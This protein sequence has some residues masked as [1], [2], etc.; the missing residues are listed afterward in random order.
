V[1]IRNPVSLLLKNMAGIYIHIPFC[2][3]ACYYCDFHFS[4]NLSASKEMSASL[5][6]EIEM[7]RG[8][9]DN[10]VGTIYFG[11]GTP[12]LVETAD[13]ALLIEKIRASFDLTHNVEITIEANPDDLSEPKLE[14]LKAIGVN[15]LSIGIQSFDDTV[16]RMLNRAH[17]S[18]MATAAISSA[19]KAGFDNISIDLIYSIPSQAPA[20]W[21]QNI[22]RA[23]DLAP[24]HISAYSLT[25]EEKTV[26]GRWR[27]KG[28]IVPVAEDVSAEEF[29]ILL[30]LLEK[31]GYE[32]YEISNFARPGFYSRHNSSYWKREKYMGIGPSAHSFN[33][34]SRQFNVSNNYEYIR[35][36]ARGETPASVEILSDEDQINDFLLTTLRTSWGT[37]LEKLRN[38]LKYD[39]M[40]MRQNYI[41]TLIQNH[42]AVV[43]NDHLILTREGK[44]VADKISS[45]LFVP[46]RT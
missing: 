32:H 33:G 20:Q 43:R 22:I 36:I 39:L 28:K 5:G 31:A 45:D 40:N 7:R 24:E 15:R 21:E 2:K 19:R 34:S 8:Y 37:D 29:D 12:S 17:D 1:Y 6:R 16:L 35:A 25:I 46:S 3:Q 38:E 27:A 14:S 13:L 30:N 26:F 18:S 11:G 10:P 23:L 4:T 41:H 42:L 9:I 44:F